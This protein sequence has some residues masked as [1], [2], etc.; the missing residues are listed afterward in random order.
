MMN[1]SRNESFATARTRLTVAM[2]CR[3]VVAM[4]MLSGLTVTIALAQGAVPVAE[5]TGESGGESAGESAGESGGPALDDVLAREAWSDPT[6]GLTLRPPLSSKLERETADDAVLRITG[7]DGWQ[8]LL[9]IKKSTEDLSL[10]QV[11]ESAVGQLASL[12]RMRLTQQK[13]VHPKNREG[14]VIYFK[15]DNRKAKPWVLGEAFMQIDP[16]TVAMLQ[17]KVDQ[18]KFERMQPIFEA[19]F[20]SVDMRDRAKLEE[21]RKAMLKRGTEWLKKVD[22]KKR[23]A[24]LIDE[25]LFRIVRDGQDIGYMKMTQGQDKAMKMPGLRVTLQARIQMGDRATDS[26]SEF[27]LSEDGKEEIWSIKMTAHPLRPDLKGA[28]RPTGRTLDGKP[29]APPPDTISWAETGIRSGN[30][31]TVSRQGPEGIED[32]KWLSPEEGY[33]SQVDLYLLGALLPRKEKA[34]MGYYAYYPAAGKITFRTERLVPRT[35]GGLEVYSRPSPDEPEQMSRYGD[36]GRL[37]ERTLENDTRLIPVGK[38]ELAAIW[39]LK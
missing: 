28:T 8:I 33:V 1:P 35:D 19:V 36:N 27:F 4:V 18:D 26:Q 23:A 37:L 12:E 15:V 11:L 9:F 3:L 6:Y 30:N 20:R 5:S 14:V 2:L 31:V 29:L 13:D 34:E 24:A 16:R 10:Q 25:Q 32:N 38:A 22:L 7:E 39:G 21:E 17:L